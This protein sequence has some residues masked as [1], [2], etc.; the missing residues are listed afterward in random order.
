M[1]VFYF[2]RR[3]SKMNTDCIK[4]KSDEN[5]NIW[6]WIL[7]RNR[8]SETIEFQV[9]LIYSRV[10]WFGADS[11]YALQI[12]C[13]LNFLLIFKLTRCSVHCSAKNTFLC[14]V[15]L[16]LGLYTYHNNNICC[17]RI[18]TCLIQISDIEL[19]SFQKYTHVLT[20]N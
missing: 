17:M 19:S 4:K 1:E 8:S 12:S 10:I 15:K 11:S 20:L 6:T 13:W 3:I 2:L 5:S 18:W 9:N 14:T 16:G 7:E